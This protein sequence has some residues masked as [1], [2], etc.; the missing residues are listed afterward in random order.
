MPLT[1]IDEL[2]HV[3]IYTIFCRNIEKF[4]IKIKDATVL[5]SFLSE[6]ICL[7]FVFKNVKRTNSIIHDNYLKLHNFYLSRYVKT[8]KSVVVSTNKSSTNVLI[9]SWGSSVS[10]SFFCGNSTLFNLMAWCWRYVFLPKG[11]SYIYREEY[12][13]VY[14]NEKCT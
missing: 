10:S 5:S 3:H 11:L 1:Y 6:I 2:R 12:L 7:F 8:W 13:K 14:S 9:R 4:A